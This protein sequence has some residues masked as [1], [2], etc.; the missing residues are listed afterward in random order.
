IAC[1][2]G[3]KWLSDQSINDVVIYDLNGKCL[4]EINVLSGNTLI[5]LPPQA[6]IVNVRNKSAVKII[7]E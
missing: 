3:V 1:K 4:R 7:V 5:P 2:E 6:Y